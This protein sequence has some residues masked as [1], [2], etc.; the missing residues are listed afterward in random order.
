[1]T[2]LIGHVCGLLLFSRLI[3][4]LISNYKNQTFAILTGFICGSLLTIW[5]WKNPNIIDESSLSLLEKL[6]YP[7]FNNIHDLY[8]IIFI[9]IGGFTIIILEK[10]ANNY[11]NV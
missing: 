4:W 7:N 6:T 5:P 10:L 9:F 11:N 2:F 8:A 3:K 1:M